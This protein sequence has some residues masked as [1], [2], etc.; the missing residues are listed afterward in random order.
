[1]KSFWWAAIGRRNLEGEL[2]Y[3]II[4]LENFNFNEIYT[5]YQMIVVIV[6]TMSKITPMN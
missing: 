5:Y 6:T 1:M 3:K 2:F 4:M